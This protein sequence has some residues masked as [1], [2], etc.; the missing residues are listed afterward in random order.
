MR[1]AQAFAAGCLQAVVCGMRAF[2]EDA[3]VLSN[4]S[5]ALGNICYAAD[6]PGL[7]RKHAAFE[8]GAESSGEEDELE[9]EARVLVERYMAFNY[10]KAGMGNRRVP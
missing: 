5:A 7:V 9:L 4:S 6:T 10:A 2:P 8:A 3:P 1:E